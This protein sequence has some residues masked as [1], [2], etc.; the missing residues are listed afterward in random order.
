MTLFPIR[1][2]PDVVALTCGKMHVGTQITDFLLHLAG[3]ALTVDALKADP[4][5]PNVS[6]ISAG[7]AKGHFAFDQ[8]DQP[9]SGVG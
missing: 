9:V 7:P 3:Q 5:V 1:N 8:N 6:I 4:V 2:S